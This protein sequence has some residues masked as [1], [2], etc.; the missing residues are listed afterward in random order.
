MKFFL[1]AALFFSVLGKNSSGLCRRGW[2]N[3]KTAKD[4][5]NWASA[6]LRISGTKSDKCILGTALKISS[7][8]FE[9]QAC[10]IAKTVFKAGQKTLSMLGSGQA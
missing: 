1:A 6:M 9:S 4:C 5:M 2:V 8:S 7:T 10:V 3:Q